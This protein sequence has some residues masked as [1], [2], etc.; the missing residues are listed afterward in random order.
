M[1]NIYSLLSLLRGKT[2][3]KNMKQKSR[4]ISKG[5]RRIRKKKYLKRSKVLTPGNRK[6]LKKKIESEKES[7]LKKIKD[8]D[9]HVQFKGRKRR[10]TR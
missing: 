1:G 3:D 5:V 4:H 2:K 10:R 6:P 8:F 7:F 9:F